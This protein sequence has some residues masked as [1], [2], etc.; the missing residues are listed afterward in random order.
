MDLI[1][2]YM[3]RQ[4]ASALLMILITLTLIVWLA[5]AMRQLSLITSQGQ[6]FWIF[7]KITSLAMPNL[8]AIVAPVALLIACLHTLNRLN[9]DSELIVLSAA[10]APV[11][12]VLRP[13]LLLGLLVTAFI[14][15]VNA[16][17]LPQSARLLKDYILQIRTDIISQVLQPGQFT[18][19]DKGLTFH[20]RDRTGDGE[21]LGLMVHDERDGK[22]IMTYLAERGRI[23]E[24]HGRSFLIMYEGHIHR[25]QADSQEV[26]IVTFDSYL[27]DL[28]QLALAERGQSN[29]DL[30]PREMFLGELLNPD[31]N[32]PQYAKNKGKIRA[33]LHERLA[34]PLYPILFVLLAVVH[35]GYARTT[36]EGRLESVVMAFTVAAALRMIGLAATNMAA[37]KA[38][39]VAL[40]YGVPAAGIIGAL[41]MLAFNIKPLRLPSLTLKLP[42]FRLSPQK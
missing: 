29:N 40:I 38:W 26:N 22:R 17:I 36:R 10:G 11:W 18:E 25:Q 42:S 4:T 37:K 20:I 8:I 41:I 34:N 16:Y 6:G 1:S 23:V 27:F 5:T 2:R 30:K 31:T 28:S 32:H 3:F 13:Y 33:E 12:R 21:L 39:A 9:G 35:L 7:F 14:I 19:A 15:A 24:Q